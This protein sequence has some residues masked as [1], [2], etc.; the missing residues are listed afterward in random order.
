MQKSAPRGE[1]W[2]P[3][4]DDGSAKY[5]YYGEPLNARNVERRVMALFKQLKPKK[6]AVVDGD[7]EENEFVSFDD[8]NVD[9]G[10]DWTRYEEKDDFLVMPVRAT[11]ARQ[12][13]VVAN[14]DNAVGPERVR[15][16][17]DALDN[18]ERKRTTT[19]FS[20]KK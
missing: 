9:G 8:G 6:K 3:N 10:V 7:D 17:Y 15:V 14:S 20:K 16:G 2:V 12:K 13:A 5:G 19:A 4:D 18:A 11:T 1:D